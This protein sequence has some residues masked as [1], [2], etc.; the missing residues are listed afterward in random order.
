V[1]GSKTSYF[2]SRSSAREKAKKKPASG[3]GPVQ[4][5]RLA[6]QATCFWKRKKGPKKG[7]GRGEVHSHGE[8]LQKLGA[9]ALNFGL[10]PVPGG[11][12]R[13]GKKAGD[14]ICC[15]ILTIAKRL[16][17]KELR[18]WNPSEKARGKTVRK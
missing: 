13:W 2:R 6:W 1:G 15:R 17:K 3:V 5:G 4:A 10:H 9:E 7:G 16:T 18:P 8:N 14:E 11:G 12:L